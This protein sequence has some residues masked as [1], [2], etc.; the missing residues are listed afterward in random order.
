MYPIDHTH[1]PRSNSWIENANQPGSDFPIQNLPFCVFKKSSERPAIGVGIGNEIL[2]LR[3]CA[4]RGLLD[5]RWAD[6]VSRESLNQLM[7][8]P[9]DQRRDLRH[10]LSG[11]LFAKTLADRETLVQATLYQSDVALML[12]CQIGDYSDFYASINHATNVGLMLRPDN[13]LLPNYKHL[14]I[15]YHGRASSIVIS[16]T[17]VRRP[18]GQIAPAN[19]GG[20]PTRDAS[21]LLDYELEVGCF[22]AQGN[23]LGQS[24]SIDDAES[25]MFGLC[26]L[27]D[28]SARDLQKWEYQPLGPF[29]AKSFA[30]TISP[31]VVTMEALA[32]FRCAEFERPLDDPTPLPYLTS[33]SNTQ[34]GGFDLQLEVSLR[35]RQ[36]KDQGSAPM[37]LTS[38]SFKNM[39]WTF[40]QML[41]HHS[42]NGCNLRPGDLLG[43]GTVSG[44]TRDSRGSLIELTWDGDREHPVPGT[45]RT[46]LILPTG[47]ERKFLADGDEVTL[48][49]FCQ[50]S[51]HRR[52]GLGTCVGTIQ[53]AAA[54]KD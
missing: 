51:T 32:P 12:P 18:V 20:K 30:T 5:E 46:P 33:D 39:Y 40:A 36:M 16:G 7:S 15:G 1:D 22:V 6:V 37:K 34:H 26:L 45:Q 54:V 19:E 17:P 28:W 13:P 42:S 48:T 25:N 9:I 24:I 50:N 47:E 52:I 53:A 23:E 27:N 11:L 10:A 43:S 38:G 44:K 14:P 8:L 21:R 31:W 41:A 3:N 49:G 35:S 2:D 29:L 4:K